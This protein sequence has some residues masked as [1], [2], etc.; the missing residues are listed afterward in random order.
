M[1]KND[2]R[3]RLTAFSKRLPDTARDEYYSTPEARIDTIVGGETQH[4]IRLR[5]A[6]EEW[7]REILAQEIRQE[8]QDYLTETYGIKMHITLD[9][10]SLGYDILDEKKHILFLLKFGS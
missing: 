3:T 4:Y 7:S 9:G 1:S 10:I 2:I 8:F 6:K 5:A